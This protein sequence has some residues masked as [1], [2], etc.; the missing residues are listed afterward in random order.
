M[1]YQVICSCELLLYIFSI[2]EAL[3][4]TQFYEDDK[5]MTWERMFLN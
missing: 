5:L 1:K 4:T 3:E 2:L